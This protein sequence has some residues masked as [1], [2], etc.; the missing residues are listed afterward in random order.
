MLDL[1]TNRYS[2]Q[3]RTNG[4]GEYRGVEYELQHMGLQWRIRS[5]LGQF[6]GETSGDAM[7]RFKQVVDSTPR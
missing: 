2:S 4:R 1:T 5:G 3:F 7:A 6:F